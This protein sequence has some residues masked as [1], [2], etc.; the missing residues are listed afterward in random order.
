[1]KILIT[2]HEGF[3][4]R[5]FL[6]KYDNH[7]IV[8]VDIK[9]GC[10]AIDFFRTDETHFD[11]VIHLAAIVGG[12]ATIEG[13]P[14]SVA[15]DLAIDA[16]AFNWALK[17]KPKKFVY[18]SSS[19]AYPVS[20]QG[21]SWTRLGERLIDLND[22]RQP[23]LTYGWAKLTGEMLASYV[24]AEGI[25][26]YIFRPFSGYGEDQDLDYP[27][28]S[29]I[30][31]GV[32]R[33][34]PFV[35]W[36][37]GEATRDFIHMEDVVN[38]VVAALEWDIQYPVNLGTGRATS[39]NELAKLVVAEVGYSPEFKH[40]LDAPQGVKHRVCV[41]DRML[42]FYKPKITLEEGIARAVKYFTK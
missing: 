11:L 25:D 6:R 26:T 1:M 31:R 20:Y 14:L 2:G 21:W 23:D 41:P 5:Y 22:V 18:F 24:Q 33:D 9:S 36:G 38:A 28:P 4:G 13:Q 3:V 12:R 29:F 8:G 32:E 17:T 19:A 39:F 30:K 40:I 42:A 35:I 16:L 10:D 34:D 15:N 7:D 37:D 27:F